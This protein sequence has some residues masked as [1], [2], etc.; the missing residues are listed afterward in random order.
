MKFLVSGFRD[1]TVGRPRGV[2][3]LAWLALLGTCLRLAAA[4]PAVSVGPLPDGRVTLSWPVT[5]EGYAVEQ[6]DILRTVS[7]WTVIS[8]VPVSA[9]GRWSVTLPA[10]ARERFFR[11]RSV[12]SNLLTVNS[13]LPSDGEGTVSIR[14][15]VLFV[16]SSPLSPETVLDTNHLYAVAAGRRLLTRADL[17]P[18]RT[19]ATLFFLEDLPGGTRVAVT[20][21]G[22]G[23]LDAAGRPVDL[24]GDR[25]PGGSRTLTFTTFNSAPLPATAVVGRVLTSEKGAGGADVPIPGVKITVD[26]LED[27]P[28]MTFFS[29]ADGSFRIEPAP[30]GRFFVNVDGRTSPLGQWPDGAYY[31]LIGKAWFAE[32]GRSNNMAGGTGLIYLPRVAS[33]TLRPVS[34]TE[35]TRVTFPDSVLAQNPAL[36][37]VEIVI[38]PNAL[39]ADDGKRGGLIGLAPVASDR[40]PEPLPEGLNHAIDISIQS[41]GPQNFDTPVPAKFPNLPDPV[42]G[43]KLPPGAKT[44]LW[45][46]NHDSGRWELQGSMT[47][48]EDGA[49]AVTDPGVGIRQPGWHGISNGTPGGGGP[50]PGGNCPDSGGNGGLLEEGTSGGGGGNCDCKEEPSDNLREIRLCDAR[51]AACALACYEECGTPERPEGWVDVVSKGKDCA[52]AARCAQK[53]REEGERCKDHWMRCFLG[54]GNGAPSA[55]GR[56]SRNAEVESDPVLALV[57]EIYAD[58]AT[59]AQ[60]WFTLETLLNKADTFEQL[61]AADQALVLGVNRELSAAYAGKSPSA[62]SHLRHR[63]LVE[64]VMA[65]PDADVMYPPVQGWYVLTDL[66]T[67]LVRRGRTETRGY[68]T[69]LILRPDTQYRIRLLVGPRLTY[70]DAVFTS[71]DAGVPTQIFFGNPKPLPQ[72]DVDGDGVPTEAEF[73]LG[74]RDDRADSDQDGIGDLQELINR[75]NPADGLPTSTGVVASVDTPGDARDVAVGTALALVAD[76]PAGVGVL[77]LTDPLRPTLT[78]RI[79]LSGEA[80]AVAIEGRLGAVAAGSGGV[81]LLDLS[82]PGAPEIASVTPLAGEARAVLIRDARVWVGTSAGKVF[83]LEAATGTVVDSVSLPTGASVS[84]LVIENGFLY[85]WANA[86]LHVVALTED[87]LQWRTSVDSRAQFPGIEPVRRRLSGGGGK[88]YGATLEGVAVFDLADPATPVLMTLNVTT[89]AGWKQLV[90]VMGTLAVAADGIGFNQAE[91]HDFS[92]YD[93]GGDGTRL[94]FLASFPT[95]GLSKALALYGGYAVVADGAAGVEVLRFMIPDTAGIPPTLSLQTDFPGGGAEIE[96]GQPGRLVALANDDVFVRSVEFLLD[97]VRVETDS[98]WPYE[99][100]FTAPERT[101]SVTSFRLGARAFDTAGNAS[102]LVEVTVPLLPD[103]TPPRVVRLAPPAD[104]TV[105]GIDAVVARFNEPLDPASMSPASIYLMSA[106]ADLEL[107]NAD[108]VLVGGTLSYS[109]AAQ[110]PLLEFSSPL[111][112]GRYRFVVGAVRDRTGNPMVS[113]VSSVFWVAP[114]GVDGD[115]DNDGLTNGEENVAGTNPFVEDT[116]G[117]GWVDEVEVHG[118]TNPRDPNSF[119]RTLVLAEPAATVLI[120]DAAEAGASAPSPVVASPRVHVQVEDVLD[121]AAAGPYIAAP[122]LEIQISPE[123]EDA[124]A[125]PRIGSPRVT[126]VMDSLDDLVPAGPHLARPRVSVRIP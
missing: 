75:S 104:S 36:A 71:A 116:D 25:A 76:G 74:T 80:N 17:S 3:W 92:L 29:A 115:P 60:L 34:A 44:A 123:G 70:H 48:S 21:N 16:L 23:L 100:R 15:E 10:S 37:G 19:R 118:G 26:G 5:P 33:G 83:L 46:F 99:F 121:S 43:E 28:K 125:G 18:D 73:V 107:G 62:Y 57:Q 61:S 108:D 64:R 49:F 85:V 126:V 9:N 67:G 65:S 52:E 120:T 20:M 13:T 11:L 105:F 98:T 77:D 2:V 56:R 12:D 59:Q 78:A 58:L 124:P 90:P 41:S 53:C 112:N 69:G 103:Q 39:Y 47:I 1:W 45:S 93:L 94:D 87:G 111:P 81:A 55:Q 63:Q 42:S 79:P 38:P 6:V 66:G 84:D 97:G 91:P 122:R 86:V 27:D 8:E 106:G 54:F 113:P 89:V 82:N 117:D 24:D 110:G 102:P 72:G 51:A 50:P 31:P 68:V 114:G 32:P 30:A 101:S 7:L 35:E 88:L 119:P 95:P 40:L 109:A 96:A 14:R 4:S 22:N